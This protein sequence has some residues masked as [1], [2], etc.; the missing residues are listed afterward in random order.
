M[1]SVRT[2]D[3]DEMCRSAD[4]ACG[5]VDEQL[6]AMG[7]ECEVEQVRPSGPEKYRADVFAQGE[8]LAVEWGPSKHAA[9]ARGLDAAV[10]ALCASGNLDVQ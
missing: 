3:S 7:A 6:R 8:L 2:Q 10:E 5:W 1:L 4:A 9:V